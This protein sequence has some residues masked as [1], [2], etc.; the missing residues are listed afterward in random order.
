MCAPATVETLATL[1]VGFRGAALRHGLADLDGAA[2]RDGQPRALTQAIS[3]WINGLTAPDGSGPVAGIEFDSR[4][5]DRLTLW[6]VYEWPGDN[7]I[8]SN[9]A[10]LEYGPVD[11]TDPDLIEAMR[12]LDLVWTGN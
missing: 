5:G 8:S 3:R 6:A 1:R 2:I 7:A 9:V 4:H 11:L 12:L 10:P